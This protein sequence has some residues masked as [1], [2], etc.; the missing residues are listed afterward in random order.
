MS[1]RAYSF[2]LE[3]LSTPSG[4][5]SLRDLANIADALQLTATRIA[6]QIGGQTGRG[7]S[8]GAIDRM[9]ELRL[10]GIGSGSTVLEM[11]LGD[12]ESLLLPSGDEET[13]AERFEEVFVALATNSPPSWADAAVKEAIGEVAHQVK[14]SGAKR[15][16]AYR[17]FG[18]SST[19]W[20]VVD[21]RSFDLGVW[22]V[23]EERDTDRITMT[24]HLDKVDLRARRFRVRDDVGHDVTLEDVVDVDAAAQLIG[25]RVVAS[26]VAE[27]E[28]GRVV[29]IIEPVLAHEVLP[30]DWFVQSATNLPEGGAVVPGSITGISDQEIDD[31]LAGFT[32]RSQ[33]SAP[34]R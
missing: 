17:G 14:T 31:F 25:K 12:S 33:R 10:S 23:V 9:S 26:G 29:R 5:I 15:V 2:R 19:P 16:T 24:G 8:T 27:R 21:V 13:V 7:R 32:H 18:I 30:S 34:S 6:R 20:Q 28:Q 22:R 3:G 11:H 4:E 1:S